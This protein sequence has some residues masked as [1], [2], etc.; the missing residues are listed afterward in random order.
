LEDDSRIDGRIAFGVMID[1]HFHHWPEWQSA[2][3]FH[4]PRHVRLV[5]LFPG[6]FKSQARAFAVLVDEDHAG[7]LERGL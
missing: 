1:V 4:D 6:L 2:T 7:P 3:M 5:V